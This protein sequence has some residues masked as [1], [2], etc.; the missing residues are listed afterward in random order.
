M[1]TQDTIEGPK[2]VTV[3]DCRPQVLFD[4]CQDHSVWSVFVVLFFIL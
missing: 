1:C 3:N 2:M 4:L